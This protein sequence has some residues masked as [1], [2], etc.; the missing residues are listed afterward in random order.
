[1]RSGISGLAAIVVVAA[2][3]S[4]CEAEKPVEAPPPLPEGT[5]FEL[6]V[7]NEDQDKA[8]NIVFVPDRAYGDMN[9]LVNRTAFANEM[10]GVIENA[11]WQNQA[12]FNG[13]FKFNYYYMTVSGS[14][15]ARTPDEDGNFRCPI[16]KWPE[17][18]E[19]DA[20]F[21]DQIIMMHKSQLRDC[22]GGGRRM[23]AEPDSFR[24]I[25]HE[26]GHTLFGLPD[27]YCCD[28]FYA[29][30]PPVLYRTR[31][32]CR[33]DPANEA[34]RDCERIVSTRD[35]RTYW[36]SQG[37]IKRNL[38]TMSGGERVWE[39]GPADW[40]VMRDAFDSLGIPPVSDPSDFAPDRWSY[41]VSSNRAAGEK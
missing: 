41:P 2:G 1:M 20:A 5:I 39:S 15:T 18:T 13:L 16:V 37:N 27:E 28:G 8:F 23:T 7:T 38:I 19:T 17:E 40:A 25:I 12:Y 22:G 24:A 32:E 14:V 31:S 10:A 35:R 21:A 26:V 33:R 4:A 34:W 9:D 3:L 11:F 36:R 30:V 29:E 6:F